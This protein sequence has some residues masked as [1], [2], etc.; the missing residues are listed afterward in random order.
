MNRLLLGLAVL[1]AACGGQKSFDSLCANQVPAPAGCNTPCDPSSAAGG[2]SCPSGYHCSPDGKCDTL[3]TPAGNECGDGYA[4]TSDGLCVSKGG[5]NDPPVDTS[6]PAVHFTAT[7]TTPTVQL[8]LDQSGSMDA[9]YGVPKAPP[10]RWDA[11]RTALIDPT[12]GVVTK[13][14]SKVVFGAT[15]YTA[16][17]NNNVN[18]PPCPRLKSTADRT[19]NNF[20]EVRDLL[21]NNK[22]VQDTPTAASI[23]AVRADFAAHPAAKDS[24]PI[25]VLATDGLPDT[26]LDPNPKDATAQAAANAVTVKAAQDA[27]AA[28]IKLF[29][30]FVGDDSAGTHPQQMANAGVGLD[31]AT[32]KAPFYVATN[33]AEMTAAFNAIVGGVLSCDLK[34][35]GQIDSTQAQSGTVTLNGAN[36]TFGTDWTVDKDG[37][38][39]HLLGTACN[40]LKTA[41]NP[42]VDATFACGAVIL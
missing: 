38:T 31:P 36:L 27:Y 34:L 39:L 30:L 1:A 8:L 5:S 41:D 14:A 21:L 23:D 12:N 29:F 10:S 35:S 40:T 3:C 37:V 33:P 18:T 6:C 32:G 16:V 42:T 17:S 2:A 7:K 4:C 9:A 24:P 15:L 28:G 26:C 11:L 13:L 22:P 25:I 20:T 19:L